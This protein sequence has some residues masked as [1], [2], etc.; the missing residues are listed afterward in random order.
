MRK[1]KPRLQSGFTLIEMMIVI[2]IMITFFGF[3]YANFRGFQRRQAL[4]SAAKTIQAD[5]SQAREKAL[6]GVKPAGCDTLDNYNFYYV[7]TTSYQIRARCANGD[8]VVK[9]VSNTFGGIDITIGT[10]NMP[11]TPNPIEFNALGYGTN[12]NPSCV[13]VMGGG[14]DEITLTQVAT[15][16]V[17]NINISNTGVIQ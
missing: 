8:Y 13:I 10:S 6:S 16:D 1:I 17:V 7:N 5:L 11:P 3:G 4:Q 14:C 15:G 2:M 9:T 12:I